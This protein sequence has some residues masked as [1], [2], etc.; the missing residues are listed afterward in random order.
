MPIYYNNGLSMSLG[1]RL[2]VMWDKQR[3][4]SV[5]LLINLVVFACV[6]LA[7][8]VMWL[9]NLGSVDICVNE[10]LALPASWSVFASHLWTAMT[11]MFLSN[12]IWQLIFNVWLVVYGSRLLSGILDE[13]HLVAIYVLGG[14]VGAVFFIAAYKFFPVLESR[15]TTDI[16]QG[17]TAAAMAILAAAA[18]AKPDHNVSLFFIGSINI[19]WILG[20]VVAIDL[21]SFTTS[22][23]GECI[24]HAGGI[25]LGFVYALIMKKGDIHWAN[26]GNEKEYTP[27]EEVNT[28]KGRRQPISDDEFNRRRAQEERDIDAILDKLSKYGYSSLT[29]DEKHFLFEQS[30]K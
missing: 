24:N 5:L 25:F 1:Q 3:A 23:P 2:R 4:L 7:G 10:Y 29:E 30:K 16:V 27:Y 14:L 20:V 9:F 21:L 11:Y 8:L 18:T 26:K 22:V 12:N 15:A 17:A 28:D 6:R 13:R 19:K